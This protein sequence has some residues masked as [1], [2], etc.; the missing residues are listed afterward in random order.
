M[1]R[2]IFNVERRLQ[3]SLPVPLNDCGVKQSYALAEYLKTVTIEAIYASP[4]L[5]AKRT[6]QIIGEILQQPILEDDR[7]AEIAF[8]KFEGHTFAEVQERFPVAYLNWRSGYRR[9]RVPDGESRF[10]VQLRMQSAWEDIVSAGDKETVAIVGHSSAIMILLAS[11]FTSLPA[12][13][14]LNTSI[15]TLERSQE[16]W[17]IQSFGETPHLKNNQ[18]TP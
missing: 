12:K 14:M 1:G 18:D 2:L 3:G 13:S 17:R 4:R 6:A 15:T 11:L 10:D 9:Y 5:R 7:L 16:I 8:G